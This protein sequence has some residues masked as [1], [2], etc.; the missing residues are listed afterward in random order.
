VIGIARSSLCEQM[1]DRP[2][3]QV[4][5]PPA[6]ADELV[7]EI[8]A[9]IADLPTYGYRRVHAL[10][11]RTALSEGRSPANHKRVYCV[12]KEHGLL[13]QR[14][15]GGADRTSR[16]HFRNKRG[17]VPRAAQGASLAGEEALERIAALSL[18]P[19]L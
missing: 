7:A 17:I 16:P 3:Q 13:L 2:R 5:R 14:H 19:D 10:L 4:G 6:P 11:R 15:A 9:V 1:K 18:N 8:K 12:M